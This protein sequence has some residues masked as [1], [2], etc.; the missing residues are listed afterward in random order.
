MRSIKTR[1]PLDTNIFIYAYEIPESNSKLIIDALN[2]GLFE[3]I[4]TESTFKE[5]YHYFRK[6]YSKS[7]ADTFRIYLF[8]ICK[9]IYSYQLEEHSAKYA[10][11]INEED[12]EQVI[13]VREFGIKYLVSYDKHFED[14]EEYVTPKQFVNLL[15]MQSRPANY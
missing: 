4:I 2:Q 5:V 7:L 11:Q 3:A 15:G 14:I 1:A 13:A 9:T 12:L 10:N 8:A 6:H